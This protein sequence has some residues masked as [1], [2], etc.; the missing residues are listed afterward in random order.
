MYAC[1]DCNNLLL[2]YLYGLLEPEEAAK[3]REH[4]DACPNCQ[5]ALRSAEAQQ[6]LIARKEQE[7]GAAKKTEEALTVRAVAPADLLSNSSATVQVATQNRHGQ[8][9]PAKVEVELREQHSNKVLKR[10]EVESKGDAKVAL[11]M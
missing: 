4:L 10:T 3:L 9:V 6:S 1:D 11:S 7:R 2:D 8:P 5:Q